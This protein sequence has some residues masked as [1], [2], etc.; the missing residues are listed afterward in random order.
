MQKKRPRSSERS[1]EE[2]LSAAEEQFGE[3]G[4]YGARIDAIAQQSGLNKN[5]L[6]IHFGS[7]EELYRQVL[8]NMYKRMEEAEQRLLDT[9]VEG[10]ELISGLISAYFEFLSQNT[11]FVN[12]LMS[13]NLMQA[14]FFKQLPREC[15]ARKTLAQLAARIRKGCDEGVF[16]SDIDENEVVLTLNTICFSSFSNRFTLSWLMGYDLQEPA[17]LERRKNQAIEIMLSYLTRSV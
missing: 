12:I 5:M 15:I 1:R 3:K 17:A 7:K 10:I 11:A 4:F 14:Q 2:I 6:Y 16:R 8:L 13:E 9:N